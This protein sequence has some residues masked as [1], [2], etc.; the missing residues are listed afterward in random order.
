MNVFDDEWGE[1][2]EDWS[3][4][5]AKSKRLVGRGPVLGASVYELG[6]GNFAVYHY[7]HGSEE[8]LVVLRGRPTLRTPDGERVL[9]EG[10][11]V[12]FPTG[13][14][15]AH[16]VRNDTEEPV[17]FIVAGT[18]VF[19]EVVEYPDLKQITVQAPQASQTGERLWLIHDVGAA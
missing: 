16:A 4:G 18:R 7:H 15:G 17:R 1:E 12:H 9:A 5:G 13:P 11:A 3:G 2:Q 8:L 19:P 6:P 10:E 14:D